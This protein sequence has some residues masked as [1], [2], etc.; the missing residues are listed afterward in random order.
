MTDRSDGA[1][2]VVADW[3]D[4]DAAVLLGASFAEMAWEGRAAVEG[5]AAGRRTKRYDLASVE[6]D[7]VV[8][9]ATRDEAAADDEGP[10]PIR[11]E[12]R[13]GVLGNP[14]R[15]GALLRAV[16]RRLEALRGVD[17]AER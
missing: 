7:A 17:S 9:T 1:V 15:E 10:D 8:L 11:L 13:A 6:G 2:V 3:D 14:G 4:L 12:A 16:A 5:D